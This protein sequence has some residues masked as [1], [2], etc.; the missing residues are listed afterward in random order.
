MN[1]FQKLILLVA[2]SLSHLSLGYALEKTSLSP[3]ESEALVKK[4]VKYALLNRNPDLDY[5]RYV[6]KN[7]VNVV[8]GNT[9]NF[10]EWVAHQKH[11]KS[12][13]TSMR[14]IFKWII[15]K[16]DEVAVLFHIHLTK[17][18]GSQLEVK[19]MGFFKIKNH[20]IVYVE[21]IT[22]LVKGDESDKNIGSMK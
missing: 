10:E 20:K 7:F 1:F 8:D 12:I 19:D 18:D 13:T 9:F 15:A 22:R 14:P 16:E 17:S 2:I 4:A 6:A 5:G 11:I 21:E 3:A